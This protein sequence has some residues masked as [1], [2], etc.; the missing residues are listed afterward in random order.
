MMLIMSS[1]VCK[2]LVVSFTTIWSLPS[3]GPLDQGSQKGDM[4]HSYP[5]AQT[6]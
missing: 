6:A 4:K 1:V 3:I 2:D 5:T